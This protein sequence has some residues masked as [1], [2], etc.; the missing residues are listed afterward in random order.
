MLASDEHGV[1]LYTARA[2]RAGKQLEYNFVRVAHIREGKITEV[3]L[4]FDDLYAVNEF[5]S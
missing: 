1:A 2:E 3:W 4:H 5:W